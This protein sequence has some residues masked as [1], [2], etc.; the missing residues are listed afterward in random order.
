M[1]SPRLQE[2]AA[3]QNFNNFTDAMSAYIQRKI[4]DD[5]QFAAGLTMQC[6]EFLQQ[7]SQTEV[8]KM[9]EIRKIITEVHIQVHKKID[10]LT[11][12][13]QITK[14]DPPVGLFVNH[15]RSLFECDFV[16]LDPKLQSKKSAMDSSF[17]L[18]SSKEADNVKI[19]QSCNGLLLFSGSGR[20]VF[21]YVYNPSTNQYKKL[22]HPDCSLDNSPYYRSVGLRMT[23]NPIK[24]LHYKLVD[25]GRISCDTDI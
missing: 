20:P 15:I 13:S 8:L 23:F 14:V 18:G 17:T 7:L 24:S 19:L 5:L 12:L 9:L 10:F 25:A 21:D 22:P 4:N 11:V 2:L 1:A 3:T 16:S 6:A